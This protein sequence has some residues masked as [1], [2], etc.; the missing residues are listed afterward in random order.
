MGIGQRYK[1]FL[2]AAS[3]IFLFKEWV[4]NPIKKKITDGNKSDS[5][6]QT[7]SSTGSK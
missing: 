5:K 7:I 2:I 6:K 3:V 1:E 4:Y